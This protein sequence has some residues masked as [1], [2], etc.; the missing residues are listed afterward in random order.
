M[1]PQRRFIEVLDRC[2]FQE[3]QFQVVGDEER[4]CLQVVFRGPCA[5]SKQIV[6][7]RGRKWLL[8][9]HMTTSEIVQTAFKAV[10]TAMEHEVR[11]HFR[12]RDRPVFGPHFDVER[13]VELCAE[14]KDVRS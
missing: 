3:W 4:T 11:E 10:M 1:T 8:S 14:R 12:Y 2:S 13:L 7:Q 5:E 6:Q 9:P